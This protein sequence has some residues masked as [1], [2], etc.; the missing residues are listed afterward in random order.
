ML[1]EQGQVSTAIYPIA[2]VDGA[3]SAVHAMDSDPKRLEAAQ[4]LSVAVEQ[5]TGRI[6]AATM[7]RR[8]AAMIEW[9][10]AQLAPGAEELNH[11]TNS[12]Q[13]FASRAAE[14]LERGD[15]S[16]LDDVISTFNYAVRDLAKV[17][18]PKPPLM[19]QGDTVFFFAGW[20]SQE[21]AG[22]RRILLEGLCGVAKGDRCVSVDAEAT[23]ASGTHISRKQA[24]DAYVPPAGG[25]MIAVGSLPRVMAA[26]RAR[27]R[28]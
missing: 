13:S 25:Q 27:A 12:I 1:K 6:L 16:G 23:L 28:S 21:E 19:P 26:I 3:A 10:I 11:L 18:P 7:Q 8:A 20:S 9:A 14:F 22:L 4:R 24:R 17:A 5:A 2:E 15:L